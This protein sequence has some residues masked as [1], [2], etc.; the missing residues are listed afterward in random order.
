[1]NSNKQHKN[2]DDDLTVIG[3]DVETGGLNPK[4]HALLEIGMHTVHDNQYK[5]HIETF[6][7]PKD[8]DVTQQALQVNG[9]PM[10]QIKT[11]SKSF[12]ECNELGI[13]RIQGFLQQ[14]GK[15]RFVAHNAGFDQRFLLENNVHKAFKYP[16]TDTLSIVR[17]LNSAEGFDLPTKLPELH[18][19]L[20]STEVEYHTSMGD[21]RAV[22]EVYYALHD[23]LYDYKDGNLGE[24]EENGD[25]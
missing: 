12:T 15:V 6:T 21:A 20:T 8:K 18:R 2:K 23:Y 11:S 4:R 25:G 7:V 9:I 22:Q 10:H 24:W 19:E 5:S 3:I 1:M 16:F 17:F 13:L 14:I